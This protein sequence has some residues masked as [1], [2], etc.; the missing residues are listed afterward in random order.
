[1]SYIS[2]LIVSFHFILFNSIIG[3]GPKRALIDCGEPDVPE[4][5]ESLTSVL[6]D[7][8]ISLNKIILSHWHPDHVGGTLQVL[9][10]ADK[11]L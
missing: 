6:Q 3:T 10:I 11:G 8:K 4:Y 2:L 1:M 7:H 9:K 5:I